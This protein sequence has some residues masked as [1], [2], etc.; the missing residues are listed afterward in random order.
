MLG[1][2]LTAL[3]GVGGGLQGDGSSIGLAYVYSE[4][5][6]HTGVLSSDVCLALPE[7]DV[8]VAQLE[9]TSAVDSDGDRRVCTGLDVST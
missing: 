4:H 3:D 6:P 7:L 9:N 1:G 8:R 2:L 5:H